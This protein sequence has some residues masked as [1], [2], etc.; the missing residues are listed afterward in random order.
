MDFSDSVKINIHSK[1]YVYKEKTSIL[2]SLGA[3]C[4]TAEQIIQHYVDKKS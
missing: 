4:E 3:Y 2:S 1:F